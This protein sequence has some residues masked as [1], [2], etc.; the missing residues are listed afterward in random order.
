MS[1]LVK[2][3]NPQS[4]NDLGL[5]GLWL[6]HAKITSK[7][8]EGFDPF[9]VVF[10]LAKTPSFASFFFHYYLFSNLGLIRHQSYIVFDSVLRS[11]CV[12]AVLQRTCLATLYQIVPIKMGDVD[13][14]DNII[15]ALFKKNIIN[16]SIICQ[17]TQICI[18]FI[19]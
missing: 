9:Q 4:K 7:C 3:H 5:P 15:L 16:Q 19:V 12:E 18:L 10:I 2:R 8:L 11:D 6:A 13:L 1:N 14:F 17:A